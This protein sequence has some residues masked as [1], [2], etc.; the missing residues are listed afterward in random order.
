MKGRKDDTG[1]YRHVSL[2]SV[3]RKI[4]EQICLEAMLRHM[5]EREEI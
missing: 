4:M 1:N 2:S 3:L 5:E